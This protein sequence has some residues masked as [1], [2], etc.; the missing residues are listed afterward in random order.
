MQS[1]LTAATSSDRRQQLL[2]AVIV[3]FPRPVLFEIE[4]DVPDRLGFGFEARAVSFDR[5][6]RGTSRTE[7]LVEVGEVRPAVRQRM[8]EPVVEID[9]AAH[10]AILVVLGRRPEHMGTLAAAHHGAAA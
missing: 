7:V 9:N 3:F 6:L 1:P 5:N 8:V 2:A 10:S 4:T